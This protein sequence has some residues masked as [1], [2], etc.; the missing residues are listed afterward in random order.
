MRP[1]V[2]YI[3]S[4]NVLELRSLKNTATGTYVQEATVTLETIEDADGDELS[5]PGYPVSMAPVSGLDGGYRVKLE[6]TLSLED[7]ADYEAKI[8]AD[9]GAGLKGTFYAPLRARKHTV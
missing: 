3:E 7:R 9:T 6:N 2:L 5:G 1:H 4:H 8:F